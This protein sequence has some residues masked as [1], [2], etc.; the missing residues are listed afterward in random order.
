[1]IFRKYSKQ[2]FNIKM[3]NDKKQQSLSSQ[4][5]FKDL[6]TLINPWVDKLKMPT[7]MTENLDFSYYAQEVNYSDY[8]RKCLL[9]MLIVVLT[10]SEPSN[11]DYIKVKEE[12]ERIEFFGDVKES[13]RSSASGPMLCVSEDSNLND[14]EEMLSESSPLS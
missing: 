2:I 6:M 4:K 11:I 3:D 5:S 8:N 12:M 14:S 1:M 9:I 7:F 10:E 13:K